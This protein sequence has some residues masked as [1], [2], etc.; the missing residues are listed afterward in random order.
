MPDWEQVSGQMYPLVPAGRPPASTQGPAGGRFSFDPPMPSRSNRT[1]EVRAVEQPHSRRK[2]KSTAPQNLMSPGFLLR[3]ICAYLKQYQ[4]CPIILYCQLQTADHL[5]ICRRIESETRCQE[6]A[7]WL[8]GCYGERAKRLTNGSWR[9]ETGRF[10]MEAY[11]RAS[12][13]TKH[14]LH[15]QAAGGSD[16]QV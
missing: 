6:L 4:N 7:E 10:R 15:I 3:G 5:R 2:R 1:H 13:E 8:Q 11:Q 14:T 12:R 16:R 9:K